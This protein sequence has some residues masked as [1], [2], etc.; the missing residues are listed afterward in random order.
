[1]DHSTV[2]LVGV[3]IIVLYFWSTINLLI[4][5]SGLSLISSTGL[6]S[7]TRLSILKCIY[8]SQRPECS[9]F[10]RVIRIL[11]VL[12]LATYKKNRMSK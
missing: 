8:S 4:L 6:I 3:A 12:S 1:M 2:L 5:R 11:R 7:T 9:V 10:F